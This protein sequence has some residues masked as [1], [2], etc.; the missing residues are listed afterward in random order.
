M[1]SCTHVHVHDF[2]REFP[3]PYI[4]YMYMYVDMHFINAIA[5]YICVT[6]TLVNYSSEMAT[7]C[8]TLDKI[9]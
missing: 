1:L 4:L 2:I 6:V 9:K 5:D 7:Q 3:K 8:R